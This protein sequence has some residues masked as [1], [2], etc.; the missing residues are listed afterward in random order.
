MKNDIA[1]MRLEKPLFFNRWVRPICMPGKGKSSLED[2]WVWGPAG[3]TKCTTLGWGAIREKGPD[4]DNLKDVEIPIVERC[5]YAI[6]REAENVCAGEIQGGHDACQG[7]KFQ[8]KFELP[9]R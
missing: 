7:K 2:D 3:K 1:L 8:I 9:L 4:P 5:K 6:D